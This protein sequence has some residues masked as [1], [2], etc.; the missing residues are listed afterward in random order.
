MMKVA[1]DATDTNTVGTLDVLYAKASRYLAVIARFMVLPANVYDS[2]MG[3]DIL[4]VDAG[5]AVGGA[6]A[7]SYTITETGTGLP[8]SDVDVWVTT[9][10]NGVNVIASGRTDQTGKINFYLDAGTVYVWRQ[11]SGYNFTNPD[12]EVVV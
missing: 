9:D 8:I 11:K 6:I 5:T 3:T 4:H 10:I 7:W 2:M 1:L 12:V